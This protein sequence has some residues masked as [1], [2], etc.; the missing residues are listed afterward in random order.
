MPVAQADIA[1]LRDALAS[2]NPPTVVDVRNPGE[3]AGGHVPGA[4]NIPLGQ[5]DARL[6][7]V[8]GDLWLICRSGAR[9]ANAAR[10][11]SAA[12]RSVTNVQGGTMAWRMAGGA[13]ERNRS[14]AVFVFPVLLCLT[15]GLAPHSPEPHLV[16]KL[17]WIAGGADGMSA[18]DWGDLL[19]HGA[20]WAWLAWVAWGQFQAE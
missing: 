3:F 12:G 19:M 5:F 10:T 18:V 6:G 20:P 1:A 14:L 4:I 11:A 15:L 17:R 7:E 13:V 16:G 9:S 8:E 2:A